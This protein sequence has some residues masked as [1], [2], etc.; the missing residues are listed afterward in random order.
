MG[1]EAVQR[2]LG[3][4][5]QRVAG[6][7]LQE[8]ADE[9]SVTSQTVHVIVDRTGRRHVEDVLLQM[10]LAQKQDTLLVLAVPAG[11]AE[12]QRLTLRYVDWLL[13]EFAALGETVR[14]HYRPAGFDGGFVLALED[15]KLTELM[16]ENR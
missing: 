2:N 4:L 9:H 16:K 6:A 11:L 8:I 1:T 10:W 7:T 15:R 5:Y 3:M 14:V 13:S 12:E